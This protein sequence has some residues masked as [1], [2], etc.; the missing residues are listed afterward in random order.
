MGHPPIDCDD[1]VSELILKG[2]VP[3]SWGQVP[4]FR[5]ILATWDR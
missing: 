1:V 2:E 5:I 4:G 3:T